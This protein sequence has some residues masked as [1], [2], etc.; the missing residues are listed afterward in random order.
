MST[1]TYMLTKKKASV[2]YEFK[3]TCRIVK[4]HSYNSFQILFIKCINFTCRY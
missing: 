2:T 3:I 1:E 4:V